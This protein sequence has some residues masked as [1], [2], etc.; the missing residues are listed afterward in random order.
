MIDEMYQDES[1]T[2]YTSVPQASLYSCD[3]NFKR[4]CNGQRDQVIRAHSIP[5]RISNPNAVHVSFMFF[6]LCRILTSG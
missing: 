3:P 2:F 5:N 6:K 1:A 4:K